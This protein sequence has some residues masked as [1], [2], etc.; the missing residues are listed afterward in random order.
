MIPVT[1][2]LLERL[3]KTDLHVHLD[4][5]LRPE[6]MIDLAREQAVDLPSTD[7]EELRDYMHVQDAHSLVDY[8]ARFETTAGSFVV[9]IHRDW[10]PR[11]ADRFW[12][13][14]RARYYDSV[15]IHRVTPGIAQFGST[16]TRASTTSGSSATSATIRSC[17]RTRAARS[18]SPTRG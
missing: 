3:P 11:G 5:S 8:L 17:S 1:R 4:G 18:S 14:L 15:Y 6:T 12:N 9:Q 16:A 13:L 2:E 10:S 7:P